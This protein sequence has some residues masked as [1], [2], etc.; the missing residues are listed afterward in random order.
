VPG[1][2]EPQSGHVLTRPAAVD[3]GG[4]A[5]DVRIA[6]ARPSALPAGTPVRVDIVTDEHPN[7]LAVPADAVLHEDE[8]TFV[9]VAGSDNK[10]HKRKVTPG[11]T[12]AKAIEITSGIKAGDAVIV[13]GQQGLPDGAA[14]TVAK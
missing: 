1:S 11:L 2:D 10:A 5:A 6:F 4:V 8:D 14:I 7:A 13:Q 12:T 9:M 3:A